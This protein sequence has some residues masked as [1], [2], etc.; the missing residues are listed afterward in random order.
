M[1]DPEAGEGPRDAARNAHRLRNLALAV[2]LAADLLEPESVAVRRIF[3]ATDGLFEL[4]DEI[5]A[6]VPGPGRGAP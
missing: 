5:E 1:T 3:K 4:A 2:R 6:G